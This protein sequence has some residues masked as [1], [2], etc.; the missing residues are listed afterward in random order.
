MATDPYLLERLRQCL[1]RNNTPWAEKRMFGGHCFMVDDKM[2][3][4]TYQGGL[5]LRV[6]PER[7]EALEQKVGASRMIHAGRLMRGYLMLEPIGYDADDQLDFWIKECLDFN[8]RAKASK[9][10]KS[11]TK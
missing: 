11:G 3:F 5:M 10:K 6:A 9:K 7:M 8:P 2:C 1:E 4:G